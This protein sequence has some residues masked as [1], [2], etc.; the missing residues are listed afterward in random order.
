MPINFKGHETPL[1]KQ[2]WSSGEVTLKGESSSVT[3]LGCKREDNFHI[4]SEFLYLQL[5]L[6]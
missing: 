4:E 3:T 2:P 6:M 1:I 5:A